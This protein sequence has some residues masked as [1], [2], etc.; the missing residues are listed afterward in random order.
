[1]VL[2]LVINQLNLLLVAVLDLSGGEKRGGEGGRE[3]F[4]MN[5]LG[6]SENRDIFVWLMP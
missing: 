5:Y 2:Q 3:V 1:M 4:W 6:N